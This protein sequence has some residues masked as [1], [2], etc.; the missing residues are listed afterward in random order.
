MPDWTGRRNCLFCFYL[1]LVE[2]RRNRDVGLLDLP[3]PPHSATS[4][5]LDRDPSSR[6]SHL[7]LEPVL[8]GAHV[9]DQGH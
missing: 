7:G 3:E 5:L 9:H 2:P 4:K 1:T 6:L 8:A